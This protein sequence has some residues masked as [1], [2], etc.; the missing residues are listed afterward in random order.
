M[1]A[2][3]INIKVYCPDR[4]NFEI[5]DS[6]GNILANGEQTFPEWFIDDNGS[7]LE[8]II[9]LDTGVILNW[10]TPTEVEIEDTIME[11]SDY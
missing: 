2:K 8:L 9:D 5:N 6:Y 7:E 1:R 3:T 4:V 11:Y 10:V